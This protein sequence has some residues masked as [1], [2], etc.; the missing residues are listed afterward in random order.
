MEEIWKTLVYRQNE[1]PK[2][3]ISN[4]GNLRNAITGTV[5]KQTINK[6]TG[7]YGVCVSINGRNNKKLFKIH[8]AVAETFIPNLEHKPTINHIDGNKLNN[9]VNNLEW[10]TYSENTKHAINNGLIVPL[11]GT[12]KSQARFSKDEV[13]YIR[14]NYIPKDKR[15]GCCALA[16]KFGVHHSAISNIINYKSYLDVV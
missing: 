1:Y 7:Y 8:R 5:Y 9:N 6:D 10:T 12:E 2:F 16:Q 15:F 13:K 11:K 3:E 14:E 4:K